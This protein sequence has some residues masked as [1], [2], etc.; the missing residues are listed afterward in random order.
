MAEQSGLIIELAEC[1]PAQSLRMLADWRIRDPSNAPRSVSVNVSRAG[2]KR[3]QP[4]L[5]RVREALSSTGL[6][7][8]CLQLEITE[9]RVMQDPEHIQLLLLELRG[10][11]V[12]LAMDDFGAGASRSAACAIIPSTPSKS[13][14]SFLS[15]LEDN[16]DGLAA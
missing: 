7:P 6:P 12:R 9:H 14:S 3:G 13:I 15:G 11:G 8:E 10:L 5:A 16:S 4:L 1:V 2:L